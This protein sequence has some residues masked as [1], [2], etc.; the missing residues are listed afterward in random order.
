MAKIH[1]PTDSDNDSLGSNE[2]ESTVTTVQNEEY[3]RDHRR[4][5][6]PDD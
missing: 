1:W 6:Q 5:I 2:V 3:I 4:Q